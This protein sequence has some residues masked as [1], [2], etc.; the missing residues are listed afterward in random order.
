MNLTIE[1]HRVFRCSGLLIGLGL[2]SYHVREL[3]ICWLFFSAP[4]LLLALLLLGGMVAC[5]AGQYF[6]CWVGTR[7]QIKPVIELIPDKVHLE[8]P[9]AIR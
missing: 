2:F 9:G 3:L 6:V 1:K 7:V 8:A 5:D 4:F